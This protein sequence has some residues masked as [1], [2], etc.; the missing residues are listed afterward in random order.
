MCENRYQRLKVLSTPKWHSQPSITLI[1]SS[2]NFHS[3]RGTAVKN[4]QVTKNLYESEEK[5][6]QR[7]QII[8]AIIYENFQ[9]D[10][11]S[12]IKMNFSCKTEED[13]NFM[14]YWRGPHKADPK[15][16]E[17]TTTQGSYLLVDSSKTCKNHIHLYKQSTTTQKMLLQNK[18]KFQ[19]GQQVTVI[20][21][22][23]IQDSHVIILQDNHVIIFQGLK[24][25][26]N[27]H[28]KS[29]TSTTLTTLIMIR[30]KELSKDGLWADQNHLASPIFYQHN[31]RI[32]VTKQ[33]RIS[34]RVDRKFSMR[35]PSKE[36]GKAP[37]R[38]A[39]DDILFGTEMGAQDFEPSRQEETFLQLIG[40]D[41][42]VTRGTWEM[43]NVSVVKE[44]IANLYTDTIES[45]LNGQSFPFFS[46]DWRNKMRVVC[47]LTA[48]SATREAGTPKVTTAKLFPS[49]TEK[50]KTKSGTCK[51]NECTIPEAKRP[52]RFF[53]SL[54]LLK[55]STHATPCQYI[56]HLVDALNGTPVDWPEIFKG[57]IMAEL[58]CLKEELL[59]KNMQ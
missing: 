32:T 16:M 14:F 58:K 33:S 43:F 24:S 44:V 15:K 35:I 48:F 26:W 39:I 25:S 1:H 31:C 7:A 30:K 51:V 59:K 11:K 8:R 9:A 29:G 21:S 28:K 55:T 6:R 40:L 3:R 34:R 27:G 2:D 37:Q 38:R 36:K 18:Q 47:Y 42:F 23:E 4:P 56:A 5:S 52:L 41:R 46:K 54:L 53:T 57:I 49:F 50:V 12:I 20:I 13:S 22:A 10:Q 19:L 45:A 17:E